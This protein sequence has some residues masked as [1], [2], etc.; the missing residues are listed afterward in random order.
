[1]S[2]SLNGSAAGQEIM[3]WSG[4]TKKFSHVDVSKQQTLPSSTY[5]ARV[6]A[7]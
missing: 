4:D 3:G 2:K 5:H 1:V 7:D 6:K